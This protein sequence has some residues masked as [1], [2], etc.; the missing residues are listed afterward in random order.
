MQRQFRQTSQLITHRTY[1]PDDYHILSPNF[2][3]VQTLEPEGSLIHPTSQSIFVF[4][5]EPTSNSNE[6]SVYPLTNDGNSTKLKDIQNEHVE[7][8]D[9]SNIYN[10][11]TLVINSHIYR[12]T[13]PPV[14]LKNRSYSPLDPIQHLPFAQYPVSHFAQQDWD[15]IWER[16]AIN[17]DPYLITTDY[18]NRQGSLPT[19]FHPEYEFAGYT[20]RVKLDATR[21][22]T[23]IFFRHGT[24]V[25]VRDINEPD[26]QYLVDHCQLVRGGIAYLPVHF[27]EYHNQ[28]FSAVND[29]RHYSFIL[30]IPVELCKSPLL[31][32]LLPD[33]AIQDTIRVTPSHNYS[34]PTGQLARVSAH[35]SNEPKSGLRQ[36]LS[37][38]L[39]T[40][41]C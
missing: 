40:F 31:P 18:N 19:I 9:D 4:S 39:S 14:S 27:R 38:L 10:A 20:Y 16:T 1:D 23:K 12:P 35:R 5:H 6:Q 37:N 32:H 34:L 13:F 24:A 15:K 29:P 2:K 11:S 7:G 28:E 21:L 25:N 41:C 8:S 3:P 30:T 22:Q 17:L 26:G 36:R 33:I